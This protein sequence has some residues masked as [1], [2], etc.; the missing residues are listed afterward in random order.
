VFA[1]RTQIDGR[2][3]IVLARQARGG[4]ESLDTRCWSLVLD[5]NRKV[6]TIRNGSCGDALLTEDVAR[7]V[8]ALDELDLLAPETMIAV[9]DG[10][11]V[12]PR[13]RAAKPKSG[14]RKV[15]RRSQPPSRRALRM[16]SNSPRRRSSNSETVDSLRPIRSSPLFVIDERHQTRPE[17]ER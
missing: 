14:Q 5:E 12:F 8:G 3:H 17:G 9:D 10:P 2:C 4:K 1:E 13:L 7:I 15:D 6:D 11:A 16:R